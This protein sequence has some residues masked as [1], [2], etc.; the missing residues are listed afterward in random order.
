MALPQRGGIKTVAE[1]LVWLFSLSI[2]HQ[3]TSPFH[4]PAKLINPNRAWRV[5]YLVMVPQNHQIRWILKLG[6]RVLPS[7]GR[8]SDRLIW[9]GFRLFQTH[10]KKHAGSV[11]PFGVAPPEAEVL[12]HNSTVLSSPKFLNHNPI[13]YWNHWFRKSFFDFVAIN[14]FNGLRKLRTVEFIIKKKKKRK[15]YGRI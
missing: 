12:F 15:S 2:C 4:A 9:Y 10:E 3:I 13:T 6:C 11:E 8:K 7:F 1:F 5:C 14:D